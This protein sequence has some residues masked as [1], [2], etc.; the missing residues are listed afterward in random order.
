MAVRRPRV[1]ATHWVHPEVAA[2]LREFSSTL[3]PVPEPGVWS[4]AQVLELASPGA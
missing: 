3:V 2:Y 1:V 4:P